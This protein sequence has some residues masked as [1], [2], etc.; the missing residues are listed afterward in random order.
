VIATLGGPTL[1]ATVESLNCG[2][3]VPEEILVCIPQQE[4]GAVVLGDWA[5]VIV[6]PT[7]IRGQVAQR[8][9]GFKRAKNPFVMQID[10][11][12]LVDERCLE[13]LIGVLQK[14]ASVAVAPTL[15]NVATNEPIY[16]P[17]KKSKCLGKLYYWVMNGQ[18]GYREG[19]IQKS[20]S[21]IGLAPPE[22]S[23]KQYEVEWLAGG[24][25]M[26]HR[27]DL[28]L[29]NYFPFSGKAYCEDVIHSHLLRCK[30]VR[31]L[32]DARAHCGLEIL[33]PFEKNFLA[34]TR[35]IRNDFVARKYFMRLSGRPLP[36]MYLFYGL[37]ILRYLLALLSRSLSRRLSN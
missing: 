5:N 9:E 2:S 6:L 33:Q 3:V 10:D 21:P 17:V 13:C 8:I 35:E 30:G 29:E 19:A 14:A 12:M 31:L 15:I 37:F 25:V 27:K 34:F 36:R 23:D 28:V 26:F 7:I 32:V 4:A 24:C 20:G 11:D 16:K 22:G 18:D 1:R